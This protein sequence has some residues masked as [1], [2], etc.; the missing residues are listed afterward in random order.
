MKGIGKHA[1]FFSGGSRMAVFMNMRHKPLLIL[2]LIVMV[3]EGLSVAGEVPPEAQTYLHLLDQTYAKAQTYQAEVKISVDIVMGKQTHSDAMVTKLVW[4]KPNRIFVHSDYEKSGPIMISDGKKYI[5]FI[6]REKEYVVDQPPA[7]I[8][9]SDPMQSGVLG[10]FGG[11]VDIISS[12]SPMKTVLKDLVKASLKNDVEMEGK[13]CAVIHLDK[14]VRSKEVGIDIFVEKRTGRLVKM[15]FD[16]KAYLPPSEQAK[17]LKFEIVEQHTG[18]Q[19]DEA[20]PDTTFVFNPPAGARKVNRFSFAQKAKKTGEP[21]AD[22]G[23]L[24]E[25]KPAPQFSLKDLDGK[26]HSLSDYKGKFVALDFWGSYHDACKAELSLLK[27]LAQKYAAQ[28]L[29]LLTINN[30]DEKKVREFLKDQNLVITVLLDS[31]SE[32]GRKYRITMIPQLVLIDKEGIVKK[33][34]PGTAT[35]QDLE[36]EFRNLPMAK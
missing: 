20:I 23:E 7:T 28:D 30:E 10:Q 18:I 29:V 26:T 2:S 4:Q 11:I 19:I 17:D 13:P 12:E 35:E 1:I 9:N 16:N 3:V 32:V 14:N 36:K 5:K 8:R 15:I 22:T 25:G 21:E 34:L 6:P 24:K 33:L 27:K 31:A